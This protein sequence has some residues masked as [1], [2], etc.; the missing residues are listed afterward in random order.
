MLY[1]KLCQN[2]RRTKKFPV[3]T[4]VMTER[5]FQAIKLLQPLI[6]RLLSTPDKPPHDELVTIIVVFFVFWEFCKRMVLLRRI[7]RRTQPARSRQARAK[8]LTEKL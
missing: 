8:V 1:R 2:S 3:K 7:R 4:N 5:N 6:H